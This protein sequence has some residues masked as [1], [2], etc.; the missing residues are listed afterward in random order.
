MAL[1]DFYQQSSLFNLGPHDP[2][3]PSGFLNG[4]TSHLEYNGDPGGDLENHGVFVDIEYFMETVLHVPADWRTQWGPIIRAAKGGPDFMKHYLE[5]RV[6]HKKIHPRPK[7]SH[8][9][10]LLLMNDATIRAA[11]PTVISQDATSTPVPLGRFV[12][13]VDDGSS[14]SILNHGSL[15]PRLIAKGKVARISC[16]CLQLTGN[17]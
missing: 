15:M 5:H 4:S 8:Y 6:R 1:V 9:E 16:V 17:R 3:L 14:D 10:S 2:N 7:E 13:I 12:H 11:F